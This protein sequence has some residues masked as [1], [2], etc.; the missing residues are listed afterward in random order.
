MDK[1]QLGLYEVEC[2]FMKADPI[3][4]TKIVEKRSLDQ[5]LIKKC[6]RYNIMTVQQFS[7][8]SGL[9][10]TTINNYTRPLII[11][12]EIGTK[13]DYC[14]PFPDDDGKGPK[15]ILRNEKSEKYLLA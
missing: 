6:L 7:A 8:L 15:F 11:D 1:T 12:G 13:L 2:K 5:D 14:F 10:P 3:F 9:T 4:I